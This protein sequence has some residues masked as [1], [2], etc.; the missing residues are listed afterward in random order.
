MQQMLL[1]AP[2]IASTDSFSLPMGTAEVSVVDAR[3]VAA[4]AV[5]A[6]T[7]DGHDRK[8]YDLTGPE[9]LSFEEIADRLS[10]ATGKK[11]SYVHVP[12]DYARKQLVGIGLPRWLVDDMLILCASYR[13]GYGAGVSSAVAEVTKQAPRTFDQFARDYAQAFR[14]GS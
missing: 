9:A 12:P 1:F 3:D 14:E 5:C 11:V 4:V 2:W 8:I 7:Q 10:R 6:L 13:E